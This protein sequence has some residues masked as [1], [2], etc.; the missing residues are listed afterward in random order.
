MNRKMKL[1][2]SLHL[3]VLASAIPILHVD[4]SSYGISTF[5]F[6]LY[7]ILRVHRPKLPSINE[8]GA[9]KEN[10]NVEQPKGPF[11]QLGE[12]IVITTGAFAIGT[13]FIIAKALIGNYLPLLLTIIYSVVLFNEV[14]TQLRMNRNNILEDIF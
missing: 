6:F 3:L 14:L 13:R 10:Q 5:I 1:S 11:G 12:A 9:E 8:E 7:L 2:L 4:D